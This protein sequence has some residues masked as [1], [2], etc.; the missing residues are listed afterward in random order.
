MSGWMKSSDVVTGTPRR[1]GARQGDWSGL[2]WT[3]SSW[4]L[5]HGLDVVD[6]PADAWPADLPLPTS[7]QDAQQKQQKLVR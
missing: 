2:G 6:L 7:A 5:K 4:E 1:P 3:D